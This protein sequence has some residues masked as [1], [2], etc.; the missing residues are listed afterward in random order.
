[1]YLTFLSHVGKVCDVGYIKRTYQKTGLADFPFEWFFNWMT[2]DEFSRVVIAVQGRVEYNYFN[3]WNCYIVKCLDYDTVQAILSCYKELGKDGS[4]PEYMPGARTEQQ[5]IDGV[6]RC[7]G[8]SKQIV[9]WCL[10]ELYWGMEDGSISYGGN[11]LHPRTTDT[12]KQNANQGPFDKSVSI[13]S[14]LL[15]ILKWAVI[16]GVVG[17]I[18]FYGYQLYQ[19]YSSGNKYGS[20]TGGHE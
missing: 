9:E 20:Y 7:S 12:E 1:M 4:V 6:A 16:I 8:A 3:D 15:G 11:V 18:A 2:G 13:L 14:D 17:V 10:S 19:G 5:T